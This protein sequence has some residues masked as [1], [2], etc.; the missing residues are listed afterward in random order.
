VALEIELT[1]EDLSRIGQAFPRG[2]TAGK[3]Y[4]DMS[5]VNR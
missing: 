1:N 2:A 4:P 5:T 3:R